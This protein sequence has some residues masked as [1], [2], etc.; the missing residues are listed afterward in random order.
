M[1]GRNHKAKQ[2]RFV[3][4]LAK[5][6]LQK[7][8]PFALAAE[9]GSLYCWIWRFDQV[10]GGR[11]AREEDRA[12]NRECLQIIFPLIFPLFFLAEQHLVEIN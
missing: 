7:Y 1:K 11:T 10:M 8:T 5:A 3:A 2:P 4:S 12:F 6:A 9:F